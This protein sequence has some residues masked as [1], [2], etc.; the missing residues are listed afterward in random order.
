MVTNERQRL[1]AS[2]SRK[3]RSQAKSKEETKDQSDQESELA[4]RTSQPPQTN[5]HGR[6]RRKSRQLLSQS[7]IPEI[8]PKLNQYHYVVEE[9]LPSGDEQ[10][11]VK[12]HTTGGFTTLFPVRPPSDSDEVRYLVNI[13]KDGQ[14]IKPRFTLNP[15]TCPGF[16]SLV[17]H[18]QSIMDDGRPT[19]SIQLLGPSGLVDVSDQTTWVAAIESIKQT[20]WMDGEVKCAVQMVET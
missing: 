12:S 2:Q 15:R 17:Q 13:I 7:P 19:R 1:Y 5:G 11:S 8:D 14:R 9:P 16:P 4:D 10:G 3:G 20:E 18:V 6:S